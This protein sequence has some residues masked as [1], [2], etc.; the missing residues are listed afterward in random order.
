VPRIK[1]RSIVAGLAATMVLSACGAA[2][3]GAER[4]ER[5][6]SPAAMSLVATTGS[7]AARYRLNPL[8][9]TRVYAYT[10]LAAYVAHVGSDGEFAEADAATAGEI[11]AAELL[12]D[13]AAARELDAMRRRYS[14][15]QTTRGKEIAKKILA[16]AGTDRYDEMIKIEM[17]SAATPPASTP[18]EWV[19][20]PTG[21][22][23]TNA[24]E[25]LW[26]ELSTITE[27]AATCDI[28]SPD[29]GVLE[30][31]GRAILTKP[32][33]NNSVDRSVLLWL[34]GPGTPGPAGQWLVASNGYLAGLPT[35]DVTRV[36]AAAAVAAFDV[37][38]LLWREKFE[39]M[40]ARPET[41]HQRW[42]GDELR[43]ARE[44][45]GHPSYP[46]GHSGF[47]RAVA[48]V[49]SSTGDRP[50]NFDLPQDMIAAAERI[51][52]TTPAD[53]ASDASNSRVKAFFHFPADTRAGESLGSCAARA[54]LGEIE[55][56]GEA[57][58]VREKSAPFDSSVE[59]A[60]PGQAQLQEG[61]IK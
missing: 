1:V 4:V 9:G 33:I 27:S 8:A 43:L 45:P 40:V 30:T 46:S 34:A 57:V 36:L 41:M 28:P 52:F 38:V 51:V 20:E 14:P 54:A 61:V 56:F 13:G 2:P 25:P 48:E 19:W 31:E 26:G 11:V 35:Q 7:L 18:R 50:I 21:L 29:F 58:P 39:H 3:E 42:F 55:R 53:A 5:V 44:T 16:F 37:G 6:T 12:L 24:I 49:L 32:E 10:L 47:S 23:R 17:A 60:N 59:V 15:E 22:F